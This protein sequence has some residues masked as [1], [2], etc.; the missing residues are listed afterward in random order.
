MAIVFTGWQLKRR[1][2]GRISL[3]M[4]FEDMR[5]ALGRAWEE[6][7]NC[8]GTLTEDVNTSGLGL[9]ETSVGPPLEIDC[10]KLGVRAWFDDSCPNRCTFLS[11]TR[12]MELWLM[13][14]D[15]TESDIEV[16]SSSCEILRDRVEDWFGALTF[17]K[18]GWSFVPG[19]QTGSVQS[20]EIFEPDR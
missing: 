20:V 16:F 2:V 12:P 14:P 17:A 3:G 11:V 4:T 19:A 6:E 7:N 10:K 8:T 1:G 15:G 5:V 9:L 13:C 18:L